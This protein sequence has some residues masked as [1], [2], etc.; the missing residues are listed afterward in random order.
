[1]QK[2]VL[3]LL[4]FTYRLAPEFKHPAPLEDMNQVVHWIMNHAKDYFLDTEHI[5]GVGDSAGAHLLVL[6]T[7]ILTNKEYA[8]TYDFKVPEGFQ[9]NALAL[10]CGAYNITLETE[11]TGELM[12]EYL[13]NGGTEEEFKA[14]DPKTIYYFRLPSM[15]CDDSRRG[16]LSRRCTYNESSTNSS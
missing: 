11:L 1:M 13:P 6:Y 9:F 2:E 3:R 7:S 12:K 15:L 5:Y 14:I 8:S 16:L 10:N 4:T